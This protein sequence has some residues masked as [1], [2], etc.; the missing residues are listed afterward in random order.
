[1]SRILI[2][3]PSKGR[4]DMFSEKTLSWL[5]YTK[6]DFKVFLEPEEIEQYS[7]TGLKS[8]QIVSITNS[9]KGLGYVLKFIKEYANSN[10]YEYVFKLDDDIQNF[11]NAGG[12]YKGKITQKER[13]LNIFDKMI[14]SSISLMDHVPDVGGI[15][16]MY[17]G[18]KYKTA[19]IE[20]WMAVN[21]RLQT[22]Y[23]TRTKLICPDWIDQI[24]VFTD[25]ATF[26]NLIK[27][28]YTTVEYGL[29]GMDFG[30]TDNSV[31]KNEGGIQLFDRRDLAFKSKEFLSKKFPRLAWKIVKKQWSIEPDLRKTKLSEI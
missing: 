5:K 3:V 18:G 14:E 15:S 2:A 20:T 9:N 23:I 19:E 22:S 8:S 16:I 27:L 13:C 24:G 6:Y 4:A 11:R 25:F 10:K 30:S 28:G 29:T 12:G 17:G 7:K 26:I 31:G 21:K 1:M